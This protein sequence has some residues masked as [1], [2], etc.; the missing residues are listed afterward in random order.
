MPDTAYPAPPSLEHEVSPEEWQG[1][2]DLAACY[3]LIARYGWADLAGTHTSMAVPG[4]G[5]QHFLINPHGLLYDQ[6]SFP[7]GH[8][9]AVVSRLKVVAQLD[10]AERRRVPATVDSRRL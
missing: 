7:R 2:L 1:R 8:L 6:M 4:S 9:P 10:I 3:R 5:N